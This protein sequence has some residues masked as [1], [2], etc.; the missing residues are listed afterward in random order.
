[1]SGTT[2]P[3]IDPTKPSIAR[4]YDAFLGGTDNYEV[5]REVVAAVRRA[6]PEAA[7][8]AVENRA[9]L[10]R[11]CRFLAG[12]AGV[13]QY[14][15]CGS[16]LPTAENTHGVV[17]R[18]APDARVVYVDNDPLVLAHGRALL[19]ESGTENTVI[20]AEDIFDPETLLRNAVVRSE[21]DWTR[22]IALLQLG[23]L[24][25]YNAEAVR[26][27]EDIMRA[28]IDAL[29]SGSYVAISHFL[30]PEDEDSATA[31][32]LEHMF[33][34]SM[35]G[36]GT[37]STTAELESLFADLDLLPPGLTRCADWHPDTPHLKPL[38]VAQ[39]CIAGGIA[40]KP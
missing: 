24:H 19:E 12:E 37:F 14:L 18:G 30:D 6:A 27:R 15:D 13:T 8:L 34:H 7:D 4:V 17:R 36:S 20:V 2:P 39:R 21:L 5:D 32:Q 26:T 16:G 23:T 29:P 35:M 25:H 40:R 9:F 38:N 33:L 10:I 11:A 28:Y 22:P 3:Y 1:M 31:R